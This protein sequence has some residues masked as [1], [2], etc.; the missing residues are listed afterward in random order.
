MTHL[1]AWPAECLDH[2]IKDR[3]IVLKGVLLI[4]F[5]GISS[6]NCNIFVCLMGGFMILTTLPRYRMEHLSSS[7]LI[8][9]Q[10]SPSWLV[11]AI[12]GFSRLEGKFSCSLHA[13]FSHSGTF[14]LYFICIN[15][16]FCNRFDE[17]ILKGLL[18]AKSFT[19]GNS[20]SPHYNLFDFFKVIFRDLS[21]QV[22]F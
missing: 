14:K 21:M 22:H 3:E 2:I 18:F 8:R 12:Q 20:T 19:R 15:T 10:S 16:A 4:I 11:S 9:C 17:V 1:R 7:I 13:R 6:C 5:V